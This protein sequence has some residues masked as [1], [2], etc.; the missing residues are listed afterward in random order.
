MITLFESNEHKVVVFRNL[1]PKGAVQSNQAVVVHKDASLLLEA[2]G[3]IVFQRLLAEVARVVATPRINYIF[4]SH[5]DPDVMGGAASWY[6]SVPGSKILLP[7][8]WLRFLPHVFPP[9]VELGE[10]IIPI[11]DEG[12]TLD[13]AGCELRFIPA[14]FLHSPGNFSVYDPCSRTLFSGDVLASL[15]PP[16]EDKDFVEDF[17]SF[18]KHA[19]PFHK[20]YM[21]SNRAIR[22]WL[23]R[24][25]GLE[26]D[27]IV[28][29]HGPV[30]EGRD[31]VDA[32][33]KWLKELRC[34]VDL[35]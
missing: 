24:I 4:F 18:V 29:Q 2:G 22:A 34:G 19:E 11:P 17:S 12:T 9:D 31:K 8:A 21:A 20:R 6:V 28:P 35:I 7:S 33:L 3:R 14:H 10:R 30:I 15:P 27:R 5:Q 25:E 1:T 23:S 16:E 26:I 32:A 13:L